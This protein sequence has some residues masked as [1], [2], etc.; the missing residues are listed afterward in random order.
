MNLTPSQV[1]PL[2]RHPQAYLCAEEEVAELREGEEDDE[3]HDREAH[4]VFGALRTGT[5]GSQ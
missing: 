2:G 5:T 1:P 4:H 3:E